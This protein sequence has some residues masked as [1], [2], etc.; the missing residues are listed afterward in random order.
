MTS[1]LS[2]GKITVFGNPAAIYTKILHLSQQ[3]PSYQI[4]AREDKN[5]RLT[6]SKKMM[7]GILQLE[8]PVVIVAQGEYSLVQMNVLN[9]KVLPAHIEEEQL[10]L[11]I[12]RVSLFLESDNDLYHAAQK[13][14]KNAIL[15]LEQLLEKITVQK[16]I[17]DEQIIQVGKALY[18]EGRVDSQE[19][20]ILFKINDVLLKTKNKKWQ[21]FFVN[22]LTDHY[23]F[24]KGQTHVSISLQDANALL[25]R[26]HSDGRVD[27]QTELLLL[28]NLMRY[29]SNVPESFYGHVLRLLYKTVLEST[30]NLF[31]QQPR[32]AGVIDPDDVI[33]I[34]RVLYGTGSSGGMQIEQD[35]ADFLF[36]LNDATAT[37]E[38]C[39]EWIEFFK[40]AIA[41]Y[42]LL[43]STSPDAVD[44]KEAEWLVSKIEADGQV[45]ECEKEL[46]R[47]L[48]QEARVIHPKLREYMEK[49]AI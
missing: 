2:T 5:H 44:E 48:K 39:P 49:Y 14:D 42:L 30:E 22:A 35:E 15:S 24:R 40:R 4:V 36:R 19:A 7:M 9:N 18:A 34:R 31:T 21:E 3:S 43:N 16:N 17:T 1:D 27:E 8:F 29:L 47:Y 11:F 37:V 46:L 23:Y 12:N 32:L 45:T 10:T 26:I 13:Q 28:T 41:M 38:N 25:E 20:E 33:A 6:F